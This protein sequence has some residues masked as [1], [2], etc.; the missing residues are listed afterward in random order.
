VADLE[1]DLFRF[2]C[3]IFS[4]DGRRVLAAGGDWKP[5]GISQVT[6]WDVASK[7]QVQKLTCNQNAILALN[8]S[9]DGKTIA[10]GGID[11][12]IHL[13]EA[14]SG[15]HLKALRGHSRWVES[16]VFTLDG[17]TLVSGGHDGTIRFWDVDGGKET[18]QITMAGVV[19]TVRLSPDGKTLFAGSGPKTLKV[20]SVADQQEQTALW[21]GHEVSVA[22]DQLPFGIATKQN[23]TGWLAAGLVGLGLVFLL[24]FGSSVRLSLW[25]FRTAS[26][27]PSVEPASTRSFSCSE[28]G[29][30][31]K[32]QAD[33]AGKK[34]KC[35]QCGKAIIVPGADVDAST[36][37]R[38]KPRPR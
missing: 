36:G 16:V 6:I 33:L 31:L 14:D 26:K 5:Q 19:R 1:G 35:P 30:K 24:S 20:F 37:I 28:C 17:K 22:M 15:K 9:P 18:N 8:Y 13:W 25:H 27:P 10:T 21:D 38:S 3:V 12:T 29:K 32:V 23:E 11:N 2:H 34:V 4:P 7:K